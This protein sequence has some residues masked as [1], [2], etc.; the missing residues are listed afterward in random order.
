[1]PIIMVTTE[2][3]NSQRD[4]AAKVGVNAFITKPFKPGA[5]KALMRDLLGD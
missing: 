1:V 3:E 4:V 5:I 2:S